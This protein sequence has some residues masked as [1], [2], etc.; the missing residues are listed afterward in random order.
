[1]F[2]GVPRDCS[3]RDIFPRLHPRRGHHHCPQGCLP[4]QIQN[5]LSGENGDLFH[6]DNACSKRRLLKRPKREKK[7]EKDVRLKTRKDQRLRHSARRL[8]G[9]PTNILGRR[10]RCVWSEGKL[11][12]DLGHSWP[13]NGLASWPTGWRGTTSLLSNWTPLKRYFI[14]QEK[15]SAL[16]VKV[17]Y[18]D[19]HPSFIAISWEGMDYDSPLRD[20]TRICREFIDFIVTLR[21]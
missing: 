2:K 9:F 10:F 14:I 19:V 18:E 7:V 11:E 15:I 6:S 4:W 1:M 5:S 3:W 17:G 13:T 20:R 8:P 21:L 16:E 12:T